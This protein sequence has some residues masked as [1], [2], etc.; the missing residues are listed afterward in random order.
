[1][2][3]IVLVSGLDG[4]TRTAGRET[5]EVTRYSRYIS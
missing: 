4:L 1:M 3:D 5:R 2:Y